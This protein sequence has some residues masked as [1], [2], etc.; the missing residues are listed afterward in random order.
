MGTVDD[1]AIGN[2]SSTNCYYLTGTGKSNTGATALTES[3]MKIQSMY[4]GFDF[5]EVW[6]LNPNAIYPY[7]QLKSNIQDSRELVEAVIYSLP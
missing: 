1:N 7:P 4:K 5:E 6:M 2:V 3:Q